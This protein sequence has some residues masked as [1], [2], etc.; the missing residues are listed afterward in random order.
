MFFKSLQQ[1]NGMKS[2]RIHLSIL[3]LVIMAFALLGESAAEVKETTT[4]GTE[5]PLS[6]RK[7]LAASAEPAGGSTIP[8]LRKDLTPGPTGILERFSLIPKASSRNLSMSYASS[9]GETFYVASYL[10]SLDYSFGKYGNLDVSFEAGRYGGSTID[11]TYF[12]KP[13]FDYLF[14]S[15]DFNLSI[16]VDAPAL[17]KKA[18]PSVPIGN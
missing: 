16:H 7:K 17:E 1:K 5:A 14:R 2:S 15:G 12:L 18:G 9:G 8:V 13:S 4:T 11:A 6:L 10:H 3:F